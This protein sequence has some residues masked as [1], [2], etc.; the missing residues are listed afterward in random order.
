ME[1]TTDRMGADADLPGDLVSG[2]TPRP[3]DPVVLGR[4]GVLS[5]LRWVAA[6]R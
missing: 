2:S 4:D 5:R 6:V 1:A 3:Q